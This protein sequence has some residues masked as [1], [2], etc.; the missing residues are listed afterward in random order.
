M[1]LVTGFFMAWGSFLWIPCPVKKWDEKAR[2]LMLVAFPWLGIVVGA[3]ELFAFWLL[4]FLSV[5]IYISSGLLT[6][7]PFIL[8][9]FIH[10]DGFMDCN[11]A[12]LSRRE[13]K[14]RQ[15]IL[16]DSHV[17]AF[18]VITTVMLFLMYFSAMLALL[19][20]GFVFEKF[21]VMIAVYFT[22]RTCSA[23]AVM[24][25]K[26]MKTSQYADSSKES[27]KQILELRIVTSVMV[28]IYG[29]LL[30]FGFLRIISSIS[31]IPLGATVIA[32]GIATKHG[33]NQLG[34]MNGDI[35]GYALTFSELI[36]L[37]V[38]AVM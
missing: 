31:I 33:R 22:S 21:I 24:R 5:S 15:E 28:L 32:H 2:N 25:H 1:R 20:S 23:F 27:K 37:M 17:G 6:I 13:L 14:K 29:V 4:D 11:D 12:I 26:P 16:K 19:N 10:L 34:G 7:I 38:L 3:I 9:G 30:W 18:A 8:T 35:S 36:G